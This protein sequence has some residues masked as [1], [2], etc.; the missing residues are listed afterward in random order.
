[1]KDLIAKLIPKTRKDRRSI[2]RRNAET[3][4]ISIESELTVYHMNLDPT[5]NIHFQR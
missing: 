5:L 2:K 1:M 4:E 3:K